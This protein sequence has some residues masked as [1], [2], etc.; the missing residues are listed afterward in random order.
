MLVSF[1]ADCSA[2]LYNCTLKYLKWFVHSLTQRVEHLLQQQW[3]LFLV[4]RMGI[5]RCG[6]HARL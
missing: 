4:C 6:E 5:F 2:F 3:W 1:F